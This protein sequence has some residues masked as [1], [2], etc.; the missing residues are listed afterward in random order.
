MEDLQVTGPDPIFERDRIRTGHL[1][2]RAGRALPRNPRGR[3]GLASI[4]PVGRPLPAPEN[5]GVAQRMPDRGDDLTPCHWRAINPG[6]RRAG[7]VSTGHAKWQLRHDDGLFRSDSQ[8]DSPQGSTQAKASTRARSYL[9]YLPMMVMHWLCRTVPS[10]PISWMER[11]SG[12]K[13]GPSVTSN[14][15]VAVPPGDVVSVVFPK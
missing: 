11:S 5:P 14:L 4:G 9:G 6:Q 13:F 10:E 15:S 1:L 12:A 3:Q 8:A 2:A 7:A